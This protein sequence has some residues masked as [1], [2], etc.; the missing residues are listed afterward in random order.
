MQDSDRKRFAEIMMFTCE[1]YKREC[2]ESIVKMY[3][4]FLAD[5]SIE[6]IAKAF[7]KHLGD[8]DQGKFWPTVAHIIDKLP[9]RIKT[10]EELTPEQLANEAWADVMHALEKYGP[11]RTPDFAS[12]T[13]RC[14]G[15]LGGWRYLCQCNF[16]ELKW[17]QKTF[18]DFYL[19]FHDT[20]QN[21]AIGYAS[22]ATALE[23]KPCSDTN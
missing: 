5:H 23:H 19:T 9:R 12:A 4:K 10:G 2:T 13:A 11:M 16:D 17:K 8:P 18:V 6:E 21:L 22:N 7:N 15:A 3:F 14:V 1:N 20:P